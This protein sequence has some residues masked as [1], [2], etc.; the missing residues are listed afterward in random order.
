[1]ELSISGGDI[2][3]QALQ[4]GLLINCTAGTVLRFLPPLTVTQAEIDEALAILDAILD[5]I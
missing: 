4:Q 3:Q 5:R 1:M 2:V